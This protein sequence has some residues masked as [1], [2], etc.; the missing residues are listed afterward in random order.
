MNHP[1]H[2]GVL[3]QRRGEKLDLAWR[4]VHRN[5]KQGP[6]VGIL[7]QNS[8]Q[9]GRGAA[10]V[11]PVVCHQP[12]ILL[13]LESV[14]RGLLGDLPQQVTDRKARRTKKSWNDFKDEPLWVH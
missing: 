7:L 9:G 6:T 11:H 1:N 14:I 2:L 5:G 12:G 4:V 13:K 8:L 3:Q 10:Q